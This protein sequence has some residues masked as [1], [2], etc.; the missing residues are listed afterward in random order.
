M[1]D[2]IL[3]TI[4][5][6]CGVQDD[7]EVFD[8]EIA[9]HINSALSTLTQLGIGPTEGFFV[10]DNAATW[11]QFYGTDK[12]FNSIRS[13]VCLQVKS[14]FDPPESSY[15]VA[16]MER[17]IEEIKWRLSATREGDDWVNPNT[18]DHDEG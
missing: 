12:R 16:A 6:I 18:G 8:L 14:I 5:K 13:F 15:A 11:T 9:T 17:Q 4:K 7:I 10:E 2:S 1:E 3:K